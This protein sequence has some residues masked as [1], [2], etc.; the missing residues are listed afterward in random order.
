M[1]RKEL[2]GLTTQGAHTNYTVSFTKPCQSD[3]QVSPLFLVRY[4]PY[5][6][7][8]EKGADAHAGDRT[9]DAGVRGKNVSTIPWD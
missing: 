5:S 7:R 6:Y 2:I 3:F 4:D 8:Y 1:E 9:Q